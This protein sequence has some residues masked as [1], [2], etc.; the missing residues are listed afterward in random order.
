M[1][2]LSE[3]SPNMFFEHVPSR[4]QSPVLRSSLY[5]VMKKGVRQIYVLTTAHS[6][7]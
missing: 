5:K 3:I 2:H 6:D 4:M 7:T 1:K